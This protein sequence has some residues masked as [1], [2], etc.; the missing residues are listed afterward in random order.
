MKRSANA[1]QSPLMLERLR[2]DPS[3]ICADSN[4]IY[5]DLQHSRRT[6]TFCELTEPRISLKWISG[7]T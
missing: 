5:V 2:A 3:L 7:S 1:S 4:G 6:K